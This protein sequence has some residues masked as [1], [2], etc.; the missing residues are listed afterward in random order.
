M[1][2]APACWLPVVGAPRQAAQLRSLRHENDERARQCKNFSVG[3]VSWPLPGPHFIRVDLPLRCGS[4]D[5]LHASVA[6]LPQQLYRSMQ[7]RATPAP[8]RHAH[9]AA[10]GL[11]VQT[12][13]S[14][15][16]S[17][18]GER[19]VI[20]TGLRTPLLGGSALR[21]PHPGFSPA[22]GYH[23]SRPIYPSGE[24]KVLAPLG[25]VHSPPRFV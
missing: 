19:L 2:C 24:P 21:R 1:L 4:V 7:E 11:A 14:Q 9:T 5:P 22:P 20:E 6:S 18:G 15:H 12:P 10:A 13:V 8:S 16:R 25:H 3:W 17:R 23:Q